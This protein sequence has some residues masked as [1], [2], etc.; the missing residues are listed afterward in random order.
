[1]IPEASQ[2]FISEKLEAIMFKS[3]KNSL[4]SITPTLSPDAEGQEKAKVENDKEQGDEASDTYD[5]TQWT[6]KWETIVPG[7]KKMLALVIKEESLID[8]ALD[9]IREQCI[10]KPAQFSEAMDGLPFPT[11]LKLAAL[12]AYWVHT[13]ATFAQKAIE[14]DPAISPIL[15]EAFHW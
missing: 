9:V 10:E 13:H 3:M 7:L 1:M 12:F 5:T 4:P 14:Q 6:K 8:T 2:L 11:P 15:S